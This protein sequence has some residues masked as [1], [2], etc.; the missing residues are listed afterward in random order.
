MP[1]SVIPTRRGASTAS[2]IADIATWP[3]AHGIDRQGHDPA[4]Y[5]NVQRWF[6][7][8]RARP[9]VQRG[10]RMFRELR[11]Q[12]LDDAAREVLFGKTQFEAR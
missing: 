3:W 10:V 1:S 11:R 4:A 7:E 2:S 6:A 8:I 9:A 12:Q 5:P